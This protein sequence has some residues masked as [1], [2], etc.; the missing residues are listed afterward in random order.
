MV[1]LR[2]TRIHGSRSALMLRFTSGS[3]L[4]M[5]RRS[6]CAPLGA[7]GVLP[8]RRWTESYA[9]ALMERLRCSLRTHSIPNQARPRLRDG[10]TE[11]RLPFRAA[12]RR[13]CRPYQ[14]FLPRPLEP[15]RSGRTNLKH[16]AKGSAVAPSRCPLPGFSTFPGGNE[17]CSFR[18]KPP[19]PAGHCGS[20][21]CI[22]SLCP[23]AYRR[24]G[25]APPAWPRGGRVTPVGTLGCGAH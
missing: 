23:R 19:L 8:P 11:P 12:H 14:R 1:A 20:G 17:G 24:Q 4:S 9:G 16:I 18:S 3:L 15:T 10:G 7:G 21:R 25:S 6:V 2:P 5:R 22:D 13:P